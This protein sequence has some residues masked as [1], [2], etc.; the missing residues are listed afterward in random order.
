MAGWL[1]MHFTSGLVRFVFGT[2]Y[3]G[4]QAHIIRP[5]AL[6]FGRWLQLLSTAKATLT[7]ASD[8]AYRL[9]MRTVKPESVDLRTLRVAMNGGD[10][11]SAET[12]E[13]FER[14]FGLHR[15]FVPTYG[16][17][18]TTFMVTCGSPGEPIA[19]DAAGAVACGTPIE[20]VEIRVVDE[21]GA[22]RPTD[23]EGEIQVRGPMVFDGYWKDPDGCAPIQDGWFSTGDVGTIDA[24][25]RLYP[26]A[27]ARA[28]IKRAGVGIPPREIEE[29]AETVPGVLR[30][31]AV[32]LTAPNRV[33]E[34]VVV[35]VEADVE[36]T[37]PSLVER[38]SN[39]VSASIGITPSRI[40]IVPPLAI[41]RTSAGKV[42]YLELKRMLTGAG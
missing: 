6:D 2:V 1:P 33:A 10:A 39:A 14:T 25:G 5:S 8:F 24:H 18:E 9:A 11:V 41:P 4:C 12:T 28:L 26:R 35:V 30:A 16:M 7:S 29:R 23:I 38:V 27:R 19:A 31:A 32:G 15:V 42:R 37:D 40:L 3:F 17:A 20:A 22:P 36:R 13:G 34:A 21:E